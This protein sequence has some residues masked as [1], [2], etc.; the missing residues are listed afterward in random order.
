VSCKT[1]D[2]LSTDPLIC[3]HHFPV[4]FRVE[5]RGE[6]R[7]VHKVTEHD[8]ELTAFGLKGGGGHS[9]RCRLGKGSFLGWRLGDVYGGM[10]QRG[11]QYRSATCPHQHTTV[12]IPGDLLR[13]EEFILEGL[14]G[15]VI[16]VELHLQCPIG[17]TSPALEHGYRL[18]KDLLKVHRDPS[19]CAAVHRGLCEVGDA[20]RA[21]V[22]R[23]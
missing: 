19:A 1:S 5:L 15:V 6:F 22:Y 12:L 16:Q 10:W 17:H 7:G 9:A 21:Q 8:R 14:K 18:V 23:K 3:T 2:N 4:L 13:V 11:G 20:V